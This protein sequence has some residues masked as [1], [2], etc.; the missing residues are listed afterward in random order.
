MKKMKLNNFFFSHN[1]TMFVLKA[2]GKQD[3]F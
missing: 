2:G 3:M 1:D